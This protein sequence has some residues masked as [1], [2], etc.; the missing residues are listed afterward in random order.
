MSLPTLPTTPAAPSPLV[1]SRTTTLLS[2]LVR[3]ILLS[4]LL[5]LVVGL[6][7]AL[8][9]TM[10]GGQDLPGG[11]D[12]HSRLASSCVEDMGG[13]AG[14]AAVGGCADIK[15][16]LTSRVLVPL[17]HVKAFFSPTNRHL[18]PPRTFLLCGPPG[19]GKT[20]LARALAVEAGVPFMNVT[21][22]TM[23]DKYFGESPKIVRAVFDTAVRKAPCILFFDEIDGLMRHRSDDD[24]GASYGLKCEFLQCM[25]RLCR[26][27]VPAFVLACT[28]HEASL[29]KAL[30]RRFAFVHTMPLPDSKERLDILV[31]M[32]RD[33]QSVRHSDLSLVA[34]HSEGLTG[35]GLHDL[36]RDACA[37]RLT[38]SASSL[39]STA[40]SSS[41]S[42]SELS[43]T[44]GPLRLEDW[45]VRGSLVQSIRKRSGAVAATAPSASAVKQSRLPGRCATPSAAAAREAVAS[46]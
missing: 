23:E 25:D 4:F 45:G 30:L 28:N 21:L 29:D 13:A 10:V 2:P 40:S 37:S 39:A 31:R 43:T 11:L 19:T 12:R 9:Q 42:A 46:A 32:T 15:A 41:L 35:S 16:H 33:E 24:Q 5:S 22:S 27:H 44:L 20:M 26:E 7:T 1:A 17:R 14:F 34:A 36:Y 38:R 3:R 8:V 18:L 6:A